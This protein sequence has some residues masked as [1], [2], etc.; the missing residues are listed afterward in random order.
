MGSST[1]FRSLRLT[2]ESRKGLALV[3]VDVGADSRVCRLVGDSARVEYAK[4]LSEVF[5]RAERRHIDAIVVRC[6]RTA[7]QA[8]EALRAVRALNQFSN[9]CVIGL[10]FDSEP[11]AVARGLKFGLDECMDA[12]LPAVEMLARI[13]AACDRRRHKAS[14]P[15]RFADILLDPLQLKVWRNGRLLRVTVAQ[16]RLLQFLIQNPGRVFSRAELL[17]MVWGN[18]DLDVGA[19]T[20]CIARVRRELNLNGDPDLIASTRGGGYSLE[21]PTAPVESGGSKEAYTEL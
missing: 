2:G 13:E 9:I 8:V 12:G 5:D 15:V 14:E 19:V 6:A 1:D 11:E 18:V 21:K 20:A 10:I 16:F 4:N 17:Q 7:M 3:V